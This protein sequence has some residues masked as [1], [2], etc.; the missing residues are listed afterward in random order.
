[1]WIAFP[2]LK[3]G[4][5]VHHVSIPR[6]HGHGPIATT[7]DP[8]S[9]RIRSHS[10]SSLGCFSCGLVATSHCN[11]PGNTPHC[12]S[13]CS[14]RLKRCP[15][16]VMIFISVFFIYLRYDSAGPCLLLPLLQHPSMHRPLPHLKTSHAEPRSTPVLMI[17][18]SRM[19]CSQMPI[20]IRF[21]EPYPCF[22]CPC[23]TTKAVEVVT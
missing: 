2:P 11:F 16:R 12:V 21:L 3:A 4:K 1:M 19:T 15:L 17:I 9:T 6:E 22:M 5:E 14:R 10:R 7:I 13:R 23:L 20:R 18:F 8:A